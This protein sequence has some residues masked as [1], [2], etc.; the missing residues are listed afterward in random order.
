MQEV[1]KLWMMKINR[2]VLA[3]PLQWKMRVADGT[4]FE[5]G[6]LSSLLA[7]GWMQVLQQEDVIWRVQ[8][9]SGPL[10]LWRMQLKTCLFRW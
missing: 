6:R 3:V 4:S 1:Y 10:A 8:N 7:S 5:S 2:A 9:A